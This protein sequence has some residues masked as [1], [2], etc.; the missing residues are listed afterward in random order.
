M[1]CFIKCVSIILA[2]SV[3]A[4][5]G[6][7]EST[8]VPP[9]VSPSVPPPV[10]DSVR[11]EPEITPGQLVRNTRVA[12]TA[13]INSSGAIEEIFQTNRCNDLSRG[14][15]IWFTNKAQLENWLSPL[16]IE[17]A[18]TIQSRVNFE[19]QGVLLMDYGIEASP[20]GG[21]EVV[22]NQIGIEGNEAFLTV[23]I[24]KAP[25]GKRQLQMVSHPCAL[26]AMPRDGFSV[27]SVRN[28]FGDKLIS[29]ENR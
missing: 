7:L 8:E 9:S 1:Y 16:S 5:C 10:I 6:V 15:F 11:I 2:S 25:P 26:Y 12:S 3:I 14:G 19:Q 20:G 29:F 28:E 17:L 22:G 13:A 4:G 21:Y 24:L 27:L 23:R 18:G